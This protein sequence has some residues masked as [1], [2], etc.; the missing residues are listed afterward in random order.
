M[1]VTVSGSTPVKVVTP[2]TA[3]PAGERRYTEWSRASASS[4]FVRPYAQLDRDVVGREPVEAHAGAHLE[5]VAGLRLRGMPERVDVVDRDLG[6]GV[7]RP[8]ATNAA[9]ALRLGEAV[10]AQRD[11]VRG[12]RHVQARDVVLHHP[13][14]RRLLAELGH[15]VAHHAE[16]RERDAVLAVVEAGH[17]LVLDEV[18]ERRRLGVV[19]LLVVRRGVG[20][21]DRPAVLAVV[22]LVPPAVEDREVQHAVERGLHAARA[23]RL[24][25]AQRVVEPHVAA[26]V[27]RLRE[28]DVVV[29]QEHDPPAHLRVAAEAHELLDE[30]LAR[31]VG[32]VRLAADHDLHRTLGVGEQPREPLG[33]AQH[34]REALVGRHA[35]RE[36]DREHLGV[37]RCGRPRRARLPSRWPGWMP[38][39]AAAP[40]RRARCFIC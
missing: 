9:S 18:V 38:R 34:Q 28:R 6:P 39:P 33:V 2:S 23:A 12:R 14:A 13:V 21:R 24:E 8:R 27:E 4:S 1:P 7:L 5:P 11:V 37:E 19:A 22:P 32:R 35:P 26:G 20:G 3:S 31:V 17:E 30:D 36:A 25:R 29:G 10:G 16:P 40:R 15:R